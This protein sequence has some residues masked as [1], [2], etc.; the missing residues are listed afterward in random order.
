G[1]GGCG[2]VW[3]ARHMSLPRRRALKVL[4]P[5]RFTSAALAALREEARTLDALRPHRNRVRVHDLVETNGGLGLVMDY[6]A[7]GPLS[8]RAP[9]PWEAAVR[10]VADACDGLADLHAG[11]LVHGDIKPANLLWDE[12]NDIAVLADFGLATHCHRGPAGWTPGFAA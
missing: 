5:D 10:Y 3:L 2:R 12:E 8:A 7:G 1:G 11:G 9:L 4:R 6:L